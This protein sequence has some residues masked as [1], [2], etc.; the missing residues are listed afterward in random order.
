MQSQKRHRFLY[1][2]R[3]SHEKQSQFV[4]R[5]FE[6]LVSA[7]HIFPDASNKVEPS[8]RCQETLRS[9]ATA[10]A[11]G[12]KDHY[13]EILGVSG[14]YQAPIYCTNAAIQAVVT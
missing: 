6:T 10:P 4:P 2:Y 11:P 1:L 8:I 7:R 5:S 12:Q 13:A 3:Y 14:T 9:V